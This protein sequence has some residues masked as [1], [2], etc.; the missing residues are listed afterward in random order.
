ME[1]LDHDEG[2]TPASTSLNDESNEHNVSTSLEISTH[3]DIVSG[4]FKNLFSQLENYLE[5]KAQTNVEKVFIENHTK[6][7]K[8][9][10]HQIDFMINEL[11]ERGERL[12]KFI[13]N[14][15]FDSESHWAD[16]KH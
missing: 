1:I 13:Q 15:N 4:H 16:W 9:H 3:L 12:E 5:T 10:A 2:Y 8:E 7:F 6:D 14:R 11:I